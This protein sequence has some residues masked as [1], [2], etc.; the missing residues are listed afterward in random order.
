[1]KRRAFT[2]LA[3]LGAVAVSASG[4]IR[5]NGRSYEG[6]CETTSDILGPYYRPDSPV[7]ENLVI[8]DMPG[9]VMELSGIVKH[10]DCTTPYKGAKVEIWHCSAYEVYDNDSD[11]FRYRGTTYCDE[12]GN[13]RFFTQMPVPYDAGGGYYRPAHFHLLISAPHYQQLVTQIYF[14]GDPHLEEDPYSALPEAT[15]RIIKVNEANGMKKVTF[16][17]IMKDRLLASTSALDKIVGVYA[18]KGEGKKI[19][20]FKKDQLLWIKNGVFGEKFDYVGNNQFVYAG[21]SPASGSA[22]KLNFDLQK[23]GIITLAETIVEENKVVC[24]KNYTKAQ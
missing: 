12:N 2:K 3:G 23:D 20:F 14:T 5:F 6:D 10:K 16:D 19:E 4:F 8:A 13:Y 24:V 22:W 7:R 18:R 21:F 11:E 1:M 9:E 17:I 15:G